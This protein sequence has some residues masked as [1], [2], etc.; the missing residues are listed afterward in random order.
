[1]SYAV[2]EQDFRIKHNANFSNL[3]LSNGDRDVKVG[4]Q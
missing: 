4:R 2:Q 3:I 1:M